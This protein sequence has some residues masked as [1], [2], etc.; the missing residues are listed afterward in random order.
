MTDIREQIEA[1]NTLAGRSLTPQEHDVWKDIKASMEKLL[2]EN[3]KYEK[4][5]KD[6]ATVLATHRIGGFSFDAVQTSQD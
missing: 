3:N 4:W 6:H 2:A 5:F 1:A